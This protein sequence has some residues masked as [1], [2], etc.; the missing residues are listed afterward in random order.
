MLLEISVTEVCRRVESG[1]IHLVHNGRG[2]A[3]IC[4]NSLWKKAS[5]FE[6]E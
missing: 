5:E 3:L 4:G 2:P 1:L 6:G